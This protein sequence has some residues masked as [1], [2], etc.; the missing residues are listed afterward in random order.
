MLIKLEKIKLHAYHGC[1]EQEHTV[2]NDYEIDITLD[3]PPTDTALLSDELSGTVNY[4]DVA[5]IVK[6]E[7]EKP[8]RLIEH[9]ATL[10]LCRL[11][12]ELPRIENAE[13]ALRKLAP[14]VAVPCQSAAVVLKMSREDLW[15]VLRKI[16]QLQEHGL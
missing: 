15:M 1:L 5:Q 6:E 13:I 11:L 12:R 2:G 4:A 16:Q 9:V 3:V 8:V 7:M 14:P 10:I